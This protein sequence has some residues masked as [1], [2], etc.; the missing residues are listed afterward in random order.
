LVACREQKVAAPL[1]RA[2]GT[3]VDTMPP[4]PTS[5]I[6]VPVRYDLAPALRWLE[7]EVPQVI[8]HLDERRQAAG[9]SRLHYAFRAT[10]RPFQLSIQGRSA[11]LAAEL[12]YQVRAWYDPPVLPEI[13]A[14]CGTDGDAPRARLAVHTDVQL[15]DQWKL[16][17]RTRTSAEPLTDTDRDQCKVT[18][19][20]IDATDKVLGAAREAL[21]KELTKFD[22]RLARFDLPHEARHIWTVLAS[23]LRVTDSLWLVIQ[24]ASVRIGLLRVHHDTLVTTVG[25]SANPRIVGGARPDLLVPPMPVPQDSTSR[26]P[27]LHLLLEGRMPYDVASAVLTKELR[28]TKVRVAGRSLQIDSLHLVGV[29]DGRVAVGL[30]VTGPVSGVLYAVGR[31][32]F[33]TA[34]S[35]LSM[36]DLAYDVGT[37]DLLV[38][39]LSWL[40]G[41]TIATF[42]RSRV[43]I[44]MAPVIEDGRALLEKNLNRELAHG[45]QLRT[46]VSAGRVLSV[47]AAP[48]A[49]VARAIASGQGELM[50]DLEPEELVGAA[51][52]RSTSPVSA[53]TARR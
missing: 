47:Q 9:N 33:D 31:P 49:L 38:G 25:L 26:P 1:P 7:S 27:V 2:V 10:R 44:D 23:P 37:R 11:T 20:K 12:A 52:K 8:G 22:R 30:G 19:F 48:H 3:W 43:Q 16:R 24:P 50:L 29:G 51:P 41:E 14:S 45:V 4:V 32:V 46:K 39:G 42:L 5:Y 28:G 21:Q 34:T 6:D 13:S 53:I 18:A 35:K 36:P 40:A 17:P 15:T